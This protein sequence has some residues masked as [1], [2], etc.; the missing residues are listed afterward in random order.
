MQASQRTNHRITSYF[1]AA[2]LRLRL[3]PSA[4]SWNGVFALFAGWLLLC[5]GL[6]CVT[7]QS[8]RGHSRL[9]TLNFKARTDPSP[10]RRSGNQRVFVFKA[11]LTTFSPKMSQAMAFS[12]P[13]VADPC[14]ASSSYGNG[15]SSLSARS[16]IA[17]RPVASARRSK[18]FGGARKL[19]VVAGELGDDSDEVSAPVNSR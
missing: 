19:V 6:V 13:R 10:S 16:R 17:A 15:S 3:S 12:Q 11:A 18:G 8:A 7:P 4:R 5:C 2:V 14:K 1:F 9:P